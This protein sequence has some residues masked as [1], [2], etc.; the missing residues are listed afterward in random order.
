MSFPPAEQG[1]DAQPDRVSQGL[2]H[3]GQVL[4]SIQAVAE[5]RG[6]GIVELCQ[7]RNVVVFG[8]HDIS[9]S[10]S[11]K[12]CLFGRKLQGEFSSYWV[13]ILN[14]KILNDFIIL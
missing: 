11:N 12:F 10:L 13:E 5:V 14:S 6:L 2:E 7:R 8:Y 4:G 1:D 9:F 3:L